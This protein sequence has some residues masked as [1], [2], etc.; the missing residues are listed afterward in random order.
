MAT[1]PATPD[2][3]AAS[4]PLPAHASAAL[5]VLCR[6]LLDELDPI[7][8]RLTLLILRRDGIYTELGVPIHDDLRAT[9]RGNL[10]RALTQLAGD[11]PDGVDGAERTKE[12]GRKRARQG[13]PLE[14]VL[15]AYRLGGRVL[16]DRLLTVSRERFQGAYDAALLDA[17]GHV[18]RL[19]DNSSS[20]LVDA[21]RSEEARLLSHD[22]GRRY[23]VLDALLAGRAE[24]PA[25]VRDA[26]R[27]LGLPEDAALLCVVAP[28]DSPSDEPLHSPQEALRAVGATSLWHLHRSDLVGLVALPAV[29]SGS[30]GPVVEALRR[31]A[32]GRVG[33]S[34]VVG[35]LAE[36]T[37]GYRL[38][39]LAARTM[40]A[41]SGGV[42]EL[43]DRLPEALL[44]DSPELTPRLLRAAF[45]DLLDLPDAERR[46]LLDTL[47]AVLEADGSPT[48][49]AQALFCHRNTVM[50]RM[51]R[52][53]K[54]TGRRL[55]DHRDRLLLSLGLLDGR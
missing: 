21:Y 7:T 38:A 25:F 42:A 24:D 51:A 11:L 41:G 46:T 13:V 29:P 54:V 1:P 6:E 27:V 3:T 10:E 36:A 18:W 20:H 30:A 34:P 44:A 15:R 45:G 39:K 14:T 8:D 49:A 19:I 4:A 50:Y 43:E 23:A 47:R 40:P 48:R 55:T 26:A 12:T 53:E 37:I 5:T 33:V 9:C 32:H 28:V 22:L 16:W 31:C 2:A 17:A 52:I 35:G